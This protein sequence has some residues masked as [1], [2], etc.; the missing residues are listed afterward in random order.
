[1]TAA[2][3][4]AG[5]ATPAGIESSARRSRAVIVAGGPTVGHVGAG[6][7]SG[8]SAIVHVVPPSVM[9][10]IPLNVS[11]NACHWIST[12]ASCDGGGGG[13]GGGVAGDAP[14]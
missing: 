2:T 8:V 1:M 12:V 3:K 11:E 6:R 14:I 7:P 4:R 9:L 13:R 10:T 5:P